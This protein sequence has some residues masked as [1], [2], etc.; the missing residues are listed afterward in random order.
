MH[1]RQYS[2]EIKSVDAEQRIVSG[3]ATT[4]E[5]DLVG[6]IVEP[7][8]GSIKLPAPFLWQHDK[9]QPI[10]KIV[11]ADITPTGIFITAKIAKIA[12]PGALRDRIDAAWLSIREGLVS[13]LS[14]GFTPTQSE[15][16]RGGG[17]R[18]LAWTLNEI[19]AVTIPANSGASITAVK[20]FD[21][22][23][24][25]GVVKAGKLGVVRLS[26][27]G[28][29]YSNNRTVSVKSGGR[30]PPKSGVVRINPH[31]SSALVV[32]INGYSYESAQG[33]YGLEVSNIR[34][35]K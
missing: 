21:H 27:N 16:M 35:D 23:R 33:R 10:G 28:S 6:D 15:P 17:L 31:K 8:G 13:G 26:G 19:S 7:L 24:R 18:F 34:V 25:S 30:P 4:P 2:F 12:E 32:S 14:I 9:N 20:R 29:R 5:V 11:K 22:A 1:Q 3:I